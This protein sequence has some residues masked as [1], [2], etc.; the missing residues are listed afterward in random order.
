MALALFAF[1]A[2]SGNDTGLRID[3]IDVIRQFG[4]LPLHDELLLLVEQR[5]HFAILFQFLAEC[6]NEIG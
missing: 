6:F 1:L 2:G 5:Q 4:H 3:A